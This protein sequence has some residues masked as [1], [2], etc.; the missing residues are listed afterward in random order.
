M[1]RFDRI[2]HLHGLLSNRHTPLPLEQ[3]K[4]QLECSKSTATRLVETLRDDLNAP[5]EYNR[6]ANG[7]FYNQKSPNKPYELPG[8][9]FNAEELHGLLICQQIL[10]KISPGILSEQ[11]ESLQQRINTML[12]KENSP[13]AVI[14]E[15]IQF[16]PIGRRLK[17]DSYFKR[18]ATALFSNQQ[19]HIHYQARGQNIEHSDR[20]LSAQKLIYYRD[21]WYLAAYCHSKNDL[22]I[23]SVDRV[24]SAQILDKAAKHIANNQLQD[25][26]Q[27]SYGIFAGKAQHTAVLEFTKSRANWVADEYWHAEQQGEWLKNGDYQ[28]SIPFSDSRELMMDILKHGAEVKVISPPFLQTL[29]KDEIEKMQK[30]YHWLTE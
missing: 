29:L 30:N 23:F 28:L 7:Y 11:I 15:K 5:L 10:Q 12:S 17:D 6:E 13:Q 3:I 14:A 18:I 21:N 22:R 4:Q 25:F 24:H 1:D 27:S 26:I 9:W 20:T 2:Y 16:P 8:L 19:I